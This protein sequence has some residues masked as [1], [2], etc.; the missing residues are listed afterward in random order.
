V[1]FFILVGA[2]AALRGQKENPGP[3]LTVRQQVDSEI[4]NLSRNVRKAS[5]LDLQLKF[6][7]KSLS[8][9]QSIRQENSQQLSEDETYFNTLVGTLSVVSELKNFESCDAQKLFKKYHSRSN[10]NIEA[11]ALE[12]ASDILDAV[13]DSVI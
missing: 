1:A 2:P 5:D 10:K 9:V 8:A 13:C 4:F 3:A 7:N 12:K 6:I 11:P